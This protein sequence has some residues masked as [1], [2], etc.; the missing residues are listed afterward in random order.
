MQ[1]AHR[2][3]R[4]QFA[5]RGGRG[6]RPAHR[7]II[8]EL[9]DYQ[10]VELILSKAKLLANTPFGISRDYPTEIANARK[11]LYPKFKELRQ[12]NPNSQVTIQFPAK[13]VVD[14]TTVT[15]MLPDWRWAMTRSRH[16]TNLSMDSN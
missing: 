13:L 16:V 4:R 3:G 8:I 10:D 7:P 1:R 15:D 5:N 11:E 12:K 6:L 9:R 14:K 2:V